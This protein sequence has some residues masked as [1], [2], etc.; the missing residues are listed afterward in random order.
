M[1]VIDG[2]FMGPKFIRVSKPSAS[3]SVPGLPP[4]K[5]D[6]FVFPYT[7]PCLRL[8][9]DQGKGVALNFPYGFWFSC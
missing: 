5:H 8:S 6:R 1:S 3:G 9:A 2:I 4:G 7:F